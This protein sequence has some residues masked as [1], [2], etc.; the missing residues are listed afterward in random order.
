MALTAREALDHVRHA[1][2]AD[3]MPSIGGLRILND[4]G[5]YLVNMHPWRWLEGEQVSLS[6]LPDQ[7]FIWLPENVHSINALVSADTINANVTLTT[8]QEL[9]RRRAS[10]INT[11]FHY[12]AALV[13][14]QRGTKKRLNYEFTA[15]Y[16]D[17]GTVIISDSARVVTFHFNAGTDTENDKY[18]LGDGAS[19]QTTAIKLVKAINSA[20]LMVRAEY[21]PNLGLGGLIV[22]SRYAGR[23]DSDDWALAETVPDLVLDSTV[24]ATQ[25]GPPMPRLDLWPTPGTHEQDAFVAYYR[26]GWNPLRNDDD[27]VGVPTWCEALY[28]ALVRNVALGYERDAEGDV[29][30]RLGNVRNSGLFGDARRRDSYVQQDFG[31]MQNGAAQFDYG[32]NDQMWNFDQTGGPL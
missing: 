15:G 20:D 10:T 28:L 4:A 18:N 32:L 9:A 2:S 29:A 23:D 27:A 8:A 1:L 5:E 25:G 3:K 24:N 13:Y 16:N 14:A 7:P 22:E 31:P 17:T 30:T 6:L 26:R 21:A 11:S 19:E 12:W